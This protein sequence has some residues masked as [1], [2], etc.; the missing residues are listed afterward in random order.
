MAISILF[1]SLMI[2]SCIYVAGWGG[3]AGQWFAAAY[4]ITAITSML[5][6]PAYMVWRGTHMGVFAA[7]VA[8]L[9]VL[10]GFAVRFRRYWFIWAAGFQLD[11]VITHFVT[12]L[13]ASFL[14]DVY[15]GLATVWSLPI[16]VVAIIGVARDR[17]MKE[18]RNAGCA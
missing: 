6:T 10:F 1:G 13:D 16:L 12:L 7:D 11:T 18:R 5:L 17:N 15:R 14:P 3:Q 4:V 8:Y 9:C 2:L